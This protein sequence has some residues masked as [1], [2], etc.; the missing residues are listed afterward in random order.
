MTK[1]SSDECR[2]N[3]EQNLDVCSYLNQTNHPFSPRPPPVQVE[4]EGFEEGAISLIYQYPTRFAN[5]SLYSDA[6]SLESLLTAAAV[7][8]QEE[9]QATTIASDQEEPQTTNT[10]VAVAVA[11]SVQEEPLAAPIRYTIREMQH[12]RSAT[13]SSTTTTNSPRASS[14][15]SLHRSPSMYNLRMASSPRESRMLAQLF[16]DHQDFTPEDDEDM[17][18]LEGEDEDAENYDDC[19]TR[20]C[21]VRYTGPRQFASASLI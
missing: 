15:R 20:H 12:V 2:N 7:G 6:P 16:T 1:M 19:Q 17:D 10:N 21:S 9:S 5:G 8:I 3:M 13:Q 4:E 14:V 11:T 18:D